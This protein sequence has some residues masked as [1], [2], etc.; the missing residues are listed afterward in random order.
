MSGQDAPGRPD[1]EE[2]TEIRPADPFAPPVAEPPRDGGDAS[3]VET[4]RAAGHDEDTTAGDQ[5]VERSAVDDAGSDTFGVG[6]ASEP[7]RVA[8]SGHVAEHDRVG[9]PD[10]RPV[11][12]EPE[13]VESGATFAPGPDPLPVEPT[14]VVTPAAATDEHPAGTAAPEGDWLRPD[15]GSGA[16]TLPAEPDDGAPG[17]TGGPATPEPDPAVR[18]PDAFTPLGTPDPSGPPS[19]AAGVQAKAQ[20]FFEKPEGKVVGAFLGGVVVSFVLKRLGRG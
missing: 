19:G 15:G 1:D 7:D 12:S 2:P 17:V 4:P 3:S 18:T 16:A 5:G 8:D 13:P 6:I 14:P 9:E 20:E 10:G 11:A